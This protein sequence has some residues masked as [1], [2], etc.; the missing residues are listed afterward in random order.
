[1]R[2]NFFRGLVVSIIILFILGNLQN[3][4]IARQVDDGSY[5]NNSKPR[6]G[7]LKLKLQETFRLVP[8]VD[9]A[10]YIFE[11]DLDNDGHVYLLNYRDN[12]ILKYDRQGKFVLEFGG[13]G[14]GPGEFKYV[15]S[16]RVVGDKVILF[17]RRKIACFDKHGQLIKEKK[18]F[19]SYYN[20]NIVAD[21]RYLVTLDKYIT[22]KDYRKISN[23]FL[24]DDNE[25]VIAKYFEGTDL[26]STIIKLKKGTFSFD[27]PGVN[28]FLRSKFNPEV[29]LIY[30]YFTR[31]YTIFV[32]DLDSNL[33]RTVKI[34]R[35]NVLL[36]E[37]DKKYFMNRSKRLSL[38]RRQL[39]YKNLPPKLNAIY[40][41]KCLPKGYLLVFAIN[42]I[43]K[44]EMHLINPEGQYVYQVI[45]PENLDVGLI[46]IVG[47]KLSAISRPEE[48]DMYLEYEIT[49]S[50]TLFK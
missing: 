5:K 18:L 39:I 30:G 34:P 14:E 16:F 44:N 11:Y 47:N 32:K 23:C 22:N 15:G 36:S 41:I 33:I 45:L 1:M 12:K 20:V 26:G 24:I 28:N 43:N 2:S 48:G 49:N 50:I 3:Y 10:I 40:D 38:E 6:F 31:H 25:K 8:Q 42:G 27:Y 4:V 29:N 13:R 21:N 46:K 19:N 37:E 9:K 17:G 35:E 7:Q